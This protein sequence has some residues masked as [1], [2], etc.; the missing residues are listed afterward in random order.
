MEGVGDVTQIES[1]TPL[2]VFPQSPAYP[3]GNI[4]SRFSYYALR[5][6]EKADEVSGFILLS[7]H[8]TLSIDVNVNNV[9]FQF[10][11]CCR[12]Q[13]RSPRS[14]TLPLPRHAGKSPTDGAVSCPVTSSLIVVI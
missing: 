5:V 7:E 14:E 9:T 4:I 11:S 8:I 10:F 2:D 12:H 13:R 3:A 1:P 6:G